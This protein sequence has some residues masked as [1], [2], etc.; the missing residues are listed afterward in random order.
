MRHF[1]ETPVADEGS[2]TLEVAVPPAVT[3]TD[4]GENDGGVTEPAVSI[5]NWSVFD[6]LAP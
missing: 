4:V 5:S 2:V 3:V 1:A 6:V